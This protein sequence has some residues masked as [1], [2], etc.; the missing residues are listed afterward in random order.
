[1]T[2][3]AVSPRNG[4]LSLPQA[5]RGPACRAFFFDFNLTTT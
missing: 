2:T 4:V 5:R 1:M 3:V